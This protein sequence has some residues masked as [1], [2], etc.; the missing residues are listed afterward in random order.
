MAA[1]LRRDP[2]LGLLLDSPAATANLHI[3]IP[4]R[5]MI[6]QLHL[7]CLDLTWHPWHEL[8]RCARAY[9]HCN[10]GPTQDCVSCFAPPLQASG[11]C[12]KNCNHPPPD[13]GGGTLC[14]KPLPT[15]L[16]LESA[17]N[18]KPTAATAVARPARQISACMVVC[19]APEIH[20]R[21]LRGCRHLLRLALRANIRKVLRKKLSLDRV[22]DESLGG[23][24][25]NPPLG[26]GTILDG[27]T[28]KKR[29]SDGL[30]NAHRWTSFHRP[31]TNFNSWQ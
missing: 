13:L 29:P 28:S 12:K 10:K 11:S 1:L 7:G 24:F 3:L 21:H 30:A 25:S 20:L 8:V 26:A 18:V 17:Q 27:R 14:S 9:L 22:S 31:D 16:L 5:P 23:R 6:T 4:M 15:H 19:L 2:D